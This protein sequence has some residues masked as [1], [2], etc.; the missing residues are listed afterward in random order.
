MTRRTDAPVR[1]LES[2]ELSAT[3]RA[4][5]ESARAVPPVQY[6]VAAG[7]ARLHAS[8]D[9]LAAAGGTGVAAK[10]AMTLTKLALVLVPTLGMIGVGVGYYVLHRHDA[11][12]PTVAQM[13]AIDAMPH[14]AVAPAVV[15][16]PAPQEKVPEV[17]P[18]VRAKAPA[19]REDEAAPQAFQPVPHAGGCVQCGRCACGSRG[20]ARA[21]RNAR[22]RAASTGGDAS[23]RPAAS[24]SANAATGEAERLA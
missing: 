7:A 12:T 17:V 18:V 1:L 2:P 5:L 9:A 15:P 16:E 6:D 19:I 4:L 22:A 3:E 11:V 23:A 21:N 24:R 13:V 20:C 8:L 14:A 10:S